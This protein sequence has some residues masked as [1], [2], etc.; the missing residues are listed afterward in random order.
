[1]ECMVCT[2]EFTILVPLKIS[3]VF[4]QFFQTMEY[5]QV[6]CT[7]ALIT[8]K[9]HNMECT[10]NKFSFYSLVQC[11]SVCWDRKVG[12]VTCRALDGPGIKFQ[13]G[14]MIFCFCPD[15]SLAP[16]ILLNHGY[17]VSFLGVKQLK[18]SVDHLPPSSAKVNK[19]VELYLYSPCEP[20]WPLLGCTCC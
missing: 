3:E 9:A 2:K 1:M 13:W 7:C 11:F 14:G 19:T 15:W 4:Q 5:E 17:H 12:I 10:E 20:S 6:I 16:P 8:F 18:Q